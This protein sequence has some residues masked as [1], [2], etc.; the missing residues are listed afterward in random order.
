MFGYLQKS[1]DGAFALRTEHSVRK[2]L[3]E[4]QAFA[5]LP[6]TGQLDER[7]LKLI[8]TP[9]CGLPDKD[10]DD[11]VKRRKRFTL[12]GPKWPY[13]NLTWR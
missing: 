11:F 5:G 12:R 10:D 3:K 1:K 13:T 9:R 6:A 2:S 4:M 7:T 8:R